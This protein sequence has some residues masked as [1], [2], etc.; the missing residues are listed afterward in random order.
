M[1]KGI[2][3][4][5]PIFPRALGRS[6]PAA[7]LTGSRRLSLTPQDA[8]SSLRLFPVEQAQSEARTLLGHPSVRFDA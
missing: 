4:I 5:E 6:S 8:I 7:T 1:Y 2:R 3:M